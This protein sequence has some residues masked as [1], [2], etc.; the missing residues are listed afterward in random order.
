M[1]QRNYLIIDACVLLNLIATGVIQEI[2]NYNRSKFDD[3]Y[4]GQK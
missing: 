4:F 2:L 1:N 3:L